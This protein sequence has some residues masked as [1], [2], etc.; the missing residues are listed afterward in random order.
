[1]LGTDRDVAE[2]ARA[3]GR[4]VAVQRE[5]ED[6]RRLVLAAVLAVELSD[7]FPVDDLDC[8]M[9]VLDPARRERRRDRA[10]QLLGDVDQV[11]AQELGVGPCSDRAPRSRSP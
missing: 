7:P 5:G 6:V 9:A 11:D 3:G 2:L 4:A 8:E 10:A 1:M